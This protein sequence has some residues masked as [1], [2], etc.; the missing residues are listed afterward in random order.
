MHVLNE[1]TVLVHGLAITPEAVSLLNQCHAAVIICPTSNQFLFH[2]SPSS[3][4]VNSL[5]NVILGSDSPLTAAGDLLDEIR[6]AHAKIGL[7]ASFLYDMVTTR[8]AEVLRLANGE[9]RLR[10]GSI[11]DI[12]AVPDRGSSPAETIANLTLAQVE[13]VILSGRIQLASPKLFQR[14]PVKLREGLQLLNIGGV[15]RWVRAPIGTLLAE[16]RRVLGNN[17][18]LGGKRIS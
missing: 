4:F 14:F 6:F 10:P 13:L 12:V 8:S 3:A 18:Q 9:G 2:V 15:Q 1:R 17:I 11:A 5:N 16:A 7:E